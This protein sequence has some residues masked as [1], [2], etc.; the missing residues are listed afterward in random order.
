MD[1]HS[2]RSCYCIRRGRL[3]VIRRAGLLRHVLRGAA[4][5]VAPCLTGC[6]SIS[7]ERIVLP[8]SVSGLSIAFEEQNH[9]I[10]NVDTRRWSEELSEQLAMALAWHIGN[11]RPG[12]R[13]RIQDPDE[14]AEQLNVRLSSFSG[15]Y[16]G[17]AS[18]AGTWELSKGGKTLSGGVIKSLVPLAEDG[19]PSL[20][21][22]LERMARRV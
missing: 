2:C 7:L 14:S 6:R 10:R 8:G 3:L 22:A 5:P 18:V 15:R 16:D 19:Y 20:V 9:I 12:I 21:A 11:G 1:R 17:Y 13:V 4:E